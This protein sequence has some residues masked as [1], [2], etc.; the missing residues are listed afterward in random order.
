MDTKLALLQNLIPPLGC[1]LLGSPSST[2]LNPPLRP[3]K[4]G[5]G[6]CCQHTKEGSIRR[7]PCQG[8]GAAATGSTAGGATTAGS[9][10]SRRYRRRIH[11]RSPPPPL[12]PPREGGERGRKEPSQPDPSSAAATVV[13]STRGRRRRR[14]R[15]RICCGREARLR[16][17]DD[18]RGE[19]IHDSL[20]L[21]VSDHSLRL[22]LLASE[23]R[24]RI[25]QDHVFALEEDL[26]GDGIVDLAG[27]SREKEG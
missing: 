1:A 11:T 18:E 16:G 2:S 9:T 24:R 13:G 10:L 5:A 15:R 20:G 8:G 21:P 14:H 17:G 19:S 26:H 12:D 25:L 22:K 6:R 23:Y 27:T 4:K 7:P 3:A